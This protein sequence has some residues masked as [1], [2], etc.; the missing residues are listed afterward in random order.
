MKSLSE[1]ESEEE[2]VLAIKVENL[3]KI[4]N[5]N[6]ILINLD[7]STLSKA[8]EKIKN[9]D[10]LLDD[11]KQ[12]F[13]H[14]VNLDSEDYEAILEDCLAILANKNKLLIILKGQG[15]KIRFILTVIQDV[16]KHLKKE[17]M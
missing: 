3:R 10:E 7:Q 13:K 17:L 1:N 15:I 12:L 6:S 16:I 14:I 4:I 9:L 5:Q 2:N 8:S 11:L